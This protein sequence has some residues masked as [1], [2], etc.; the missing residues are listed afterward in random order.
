MCLLL[1]LVRHHVHDD[2]LDIV[3]FLGEQGKHLSRCSADRMSI[4]LHE[5]LQSF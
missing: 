3:I 2:E 4:E 1:L 5:I